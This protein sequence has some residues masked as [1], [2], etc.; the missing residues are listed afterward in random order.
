MRN[1]LI[2]G[3][4]QAGLITATTIKA[5]FPE[6]DVTVVASSEIP[7]IGVGEGSTEQWTAY[8]KRVGINRPQL[9]KES[10]ATLKHGIRF[11]HWNPVRMRFLH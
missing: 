6:F 3:S 11:L 1:I 2:V 7:P 9:L 5:C 10:M 8:E 4:G